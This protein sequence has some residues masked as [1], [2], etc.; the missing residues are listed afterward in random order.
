MNLSRLER[1]II[2]VAVVAS[3]LAVFLIGVRAGI[4]R[5]RMLQERETSAAEYRAN[6]LEASLNECREDGPKVARKERRK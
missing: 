3:V 5:G 1:A 4:Y 2:T 6:T